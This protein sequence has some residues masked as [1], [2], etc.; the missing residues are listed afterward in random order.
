MGLPFR[1]WVEN[2]SIEWK[3]TDFPVKKSFRMQQWV[4]KVM[5]TVVWNIKGRTDFLE[6][7]GTCKLRFR[8]LRA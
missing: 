2:H 5:Q 8:Y 7:G 1:A 4:K 3:H 6:K